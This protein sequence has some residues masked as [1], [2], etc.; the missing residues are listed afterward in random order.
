MSSLRTLF[1][2][3][4]N[5]EIPSHEDLTRGP[6]RLPPVKPIEQN[7]DHKSDKDSYNKNPYLDASFSVYSW[8]HSIGLEHHAHVFE[9]GGESAH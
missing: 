1:L 7:D 8:L 6:E 5:S 4:R 3:A 9:A 2:S